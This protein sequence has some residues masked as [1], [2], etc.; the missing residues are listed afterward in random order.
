MKDSAF[1]QFING[2]MT[3]E[4]IKLEFSR[5]LTA[6]ANSNRDDLASVTSIG[7]EANVEAQETE[8]DVDT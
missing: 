2:K 5:L 1:D 8:N 6:K 4:A 3:F 7:G